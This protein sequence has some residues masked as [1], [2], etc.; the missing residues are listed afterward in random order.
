[1]RSSSVR[2]VLLAATLTTT[3]LAIDFGGGN[4]A[5]QTAGTVAPTQATDGSS[6]TSG[7]NGFGNFGMETNPALSGDSGQAVR[8]I[9][10]AGV[11][12]KDGHHPVGVKAG[13]CQTKANGPIKV[14]NLIAEVKAGGV[15]VKG[16]QHQVVVKTRERSVSIAAAQRQAGG[17]HRAGAK[18]GELWASTAVAP[19]KAR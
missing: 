15:A 5:T 16:G 2:H 7:A 8:V 4:D 11:V 17:L 10:A 18:A 19:M 3:S 6:L 12:V 1:M 13:G 14:G 9:K